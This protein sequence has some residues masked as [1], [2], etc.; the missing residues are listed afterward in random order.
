[1]K[2]MKTNEPT[3]FKEQFEQ[4]LKSIKHCELMEQI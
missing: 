1:M 4:N 2:P 3:N